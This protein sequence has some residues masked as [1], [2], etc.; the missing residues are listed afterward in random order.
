MIVRI[1]P[2]LEKALSVWTASDEG[3]VG[4]LLGQVATELLHAVA[5]TF[6]SVA[7]VTRDTERLGVVARPRGVSALPDETLR[8]FLA[9][10][11]ASGSTCKVRDHALDTVRFIDAHFR[12]SIVVVG[13]VPAIL[14]VGSELVVWG[15]LIGGVTPK[16]ISEMQTLT[17]EL[18]RWLDSSRV[19]LLSVLEL[20]RR[21]REC[22]ERLGEMTSIA[23]DVRAP[24]ATLSYLLSDLGRSHADLSEDAQRIQSELWY[25]NTLMEGF[26]P[27]PRSK[28]RDESAVCDV[29]AILR[30]VSDRFAHEALEAGISFIWD[31]P[32][33]EASAHFDPLV[34][35]RALSNILGNA[36]K[37]SGAPQ[38]R[39]EL[40]EQ[41]SSLLARIVD[42]GVGIPRAVLERVSLATVDSQVALDSIRAAAGWGVGLLSTKNLIEGCGGQLRVRSCAGETCIE[43][44]LPK[45]LGV[46]HTKG[47]GEVAVVSSRRPL[48]GQA[49][50]VLVDD[51][52]QHS[53]SLERVL[54]R[55]GLMA[56]SCDSVDGALSYL[57]ENSVA[58]IV[59][60]ARMPDGGAERVL[61]ALRLSGSDRPVA[62]MS[63]EADDA[64][65]YRFAALGASEF[66]AKPIDVERFVAWVSSPMQEGGAPI[67]SMK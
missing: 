67:Y 64:I 22:R 31:V 52:A 30:R 7:I 66:F 35:E 15:G 41:R 11:I 53:A 13:S 34:V 29:V 12:T 50:V 23:H 20:R 33:R 40:V 17:A 16:L 25:L 65:L 51:D 26:S 62:V 49:Q 61:Q 38:V 58:R 44:E 45:S 10:T 42:S 54:K 14:G 2:A 43:I 19:T 48:Y 56:T 9:E 59:C 6:A 39:F 5:P 28:S 63:G 3:D 36:I 47:K 24:L 18:S 21:G 55:A 27:G 46:L 37:H 60:D 4:E 8:G 32:Y 57:R 1:T